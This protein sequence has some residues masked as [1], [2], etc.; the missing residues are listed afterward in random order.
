MHGFGPS[1]LTRV[2]EAARDDIALRMSESLL[3]GQDAAIGQ[4]LNIRVIARQRKYAGAGTIQVGSAV[5]YPSDRKL[6]AYQPRHNHRR[7]HSGVFAIVRG[8]VLDCR[9]GSAYD[10]FK[11][12]AAGDGI[13]G[14]RALVVFKC[15]GSHVYSYGR[16]HLAGIHATHAVSHHHHN[17]AI[18]DGYCSVRS[19]AVGEGRISGRCLRGYQ[20]QAAV[21]VSLPRCRG[22][23]FPG[24]IGMAVQLEYKFLVHI[25]VV[26]F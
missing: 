5:A 23:E 22:L 9:I 26:F 7:A 25:V 4:F 20:Q 16:C 24:C 18:A 1:R 15:F 2:A 21:L 17:A 10:I 12:A 3:V 13:L 11:Y 6:V 19:P 14:A 8:I